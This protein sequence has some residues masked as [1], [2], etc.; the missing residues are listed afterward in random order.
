MSGERG[1]GRREERGWGVQI[2]RGNGVKGR[3]GEENRVKRKGGG[4]GKRDRSSIML[5]ILG[6]ASPELPVPAWIS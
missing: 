1:G 3:S 4:R 2:M 6:K 5:G